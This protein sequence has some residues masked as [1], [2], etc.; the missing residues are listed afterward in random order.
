MKA[1]LPK[2]IN[3]AKLNATNPWVGNMI[4]EIKP[5][6]NTNSYIINIMH[7][8]RLEFSHQFDHNIE[9]LGHFDIYKIAR[10]FQHVAGLIDAT[11]PILPKR[12]NS[13]RPYIEPASIHIDA[14]EIGIVMHAKKLITP[15]EPRIKLLLY[16][17]IP[18]SQANTSDTPLRGPLYKIDQMLIHVKDAEI[19]GT[20]FIS[21]LDSCLE[22]RRNSN[23]VV[24]CDNFEDPHGYYEL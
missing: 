4:L 18:P 1:S 22:Q 3:M 14:V 6:I 16:I 2:D 17:L 21:E 19:F 5:I 8:D 23:Q 13:N 15:H 7:N 24:E 11:L 10:A 20:Q 9:Y 12:R